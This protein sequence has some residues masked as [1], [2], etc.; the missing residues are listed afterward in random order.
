MPAIL[1]IAL[2][3]FAI[4]LGPLVGLAS[5]NTLAEQA[6]VAFYIPHNGWTYLSMWGLMLTFSGSRGA[7]KK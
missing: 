6:G 7:S 4:L 2:I 1:V 3:I 5:I